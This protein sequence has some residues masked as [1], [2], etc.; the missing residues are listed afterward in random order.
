MKNQPINVPRASLS[1][2][3]LTYRGYKTIDAYT[4]CMIFCLCT[5]IHMASKGIIEN[6]GIKQVCIALDA[7]QA[8][9]NKPYSLN[10]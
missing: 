2:Y 10:I 6:K 3:E 8:L 5:E 4:L 9:Q 7:G 1:L